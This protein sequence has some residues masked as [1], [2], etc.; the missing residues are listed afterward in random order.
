MRTYNSIKNMIFSVL[1]N[2][3]TILIGFVVQKVLIIQIISSFGY[4]TNNRNRYKDFF[5]RID[6]FFKQY[7][8]K[9][10]CAQFRVSEPSSAETGHRIYHKLC[11]FFYLVYA[12][13]PTTSSN[14]AGV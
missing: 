6:L 1:S 4:Y 11:M 10:K 8:S 7:D 2:A 5:S 9:T 14:K 13:P 3:L 12:P